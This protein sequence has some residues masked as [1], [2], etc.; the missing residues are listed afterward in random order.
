MRQG[1]G[2]HGRAGQ[3]RGIVAMANGGKD[4][5]KSQFFMTLGPCDWLNG[6]HTIF[7]KAR[8]HPARARAR[9]RAA[10]AHATRAPPHIGRLGPRPC[11]GG[12][13]GGA[14]SPSRPQG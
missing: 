12:W 11:C 14:K 9:A 10:R 3:V 1:H 5:N 7:G 8:A 6:K 13:S 2:A 4:D